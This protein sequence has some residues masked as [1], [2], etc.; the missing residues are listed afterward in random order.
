MAISLLLASCAAKPQTSDSDSRATESYPLP[1]VA[2]SI[3]LP[4]QR[5]S[6][7]AAAFWDNAVFAPGDEVSAG[8]EQ[9][10][11]NFFAIAVIADD[12][13]SVRS[14]IATLLRKGGIDRIMPVAERYLYEPNSPLR[15]EELF[16][17]FLEG[18]PQWYRSEAL[19]EQALK[20]RMGTIAADFTFVDTNGTRS[21]LS[22]FVTRNGKTL[23]YFFDSECEICKELI[24]YANDAAGSMAVL[25]ICPDRN[26]SQFD[27]TAKLFPANWTVGRDLGTIDRDER[28]IFPALPS[29]YVIGPDM[30]VICKDLQL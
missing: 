14:G 12:D 13:Q 21:S 2:K 11:S 3:T 22:E 6:A 10:L 5:A 1:A 30:T 4:E 7:A 9:A 29:A 20:N 15:N 18:A 19:L 28:Y 24:P 23:V 26:A 25:A 8:L 27:A 17:R 16:I